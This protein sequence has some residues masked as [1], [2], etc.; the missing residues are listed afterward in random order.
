MEVGTL[1]VIELGRLVEGNVSPRCNEASDLG[2]QVDDPLM[3]GLMASFKPV[4]DPLVVL[5]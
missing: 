1:E 5:P 4:V 3:D 2:V